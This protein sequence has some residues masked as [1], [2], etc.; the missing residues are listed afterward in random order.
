[1]ISVLGHHDV[2]RFRATITSRLGLQFEDAKLEFLG[3]VLRGRLKKLNLSGEDYLQRLEDTSTN[4][5]IGTLGREL[6][7]GE[8]YFFRNVEQFD[9]LAQIVIPKLM[10][11]RANVKTLR[12]LSAGC[13]SGEEAYSVAL[14]IR[15]T[16]MDPEW[17]VSIRAIDLN[18]AALE[19]ARA[20]NFSNWALRA[21]P[22]DIQRQWFEPGGHGK[23]LDATVRKMVTFEQKNLASDDPELWQPGTYDVIFCRNVLMY[24]AP[25]QARTLMARIAQALAPG[26]YLFLG[27]AETLRGLS[28][29]FH[30]CHTHRTFYYARAETMDGAL[31]QAKLNP[32]AGQEFPRLVRA[33][34]VPNFGEAWFDAIH[35]ASER[36]AALVTPRMPANPADTPIASD[37]NML[38][39][40][41][42]LRRERFTEALAYV[43][44]LP[45]DLRRNPDVL[46]LEA[47]LLAHNG[48]LVSAQEACRNLLDIDEFN[49]GA[50]YIMA[51][52]RENAQDL[53]GAAEHDRIALYLDPGF[54]MPRL[55]LGLLA[56]RG[57][58]RDTARRDLGQALHL[59][60][61]EDASRLLLFGGGFNR[62]ALLVLC[63]SALRDCG[64]QP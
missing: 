18:A 58:D 62:Q 47:M 36:V 11:E 34:P 40:L 52:C 54:A 9:A 5:D 14:V 32:P 61:S 19:K 38:G 59:L 25:Q 46:L 35:R 48:D 30:L 42:L 15:A 23:V 63:E 3:E 13:A 51:L 22:P 53:A 26:G 24:F 56:R 45:R 7:V 44:E 31:P 4:A 64:G 16:A 39:A 21:T 49:A 55:H 2:E 57:G 6:T 41:D 12:I 60:R 27:H 28:E 37:R 50:H 8:T 20:A 43:R 29:A 10:R 1:M 17:N 33:V